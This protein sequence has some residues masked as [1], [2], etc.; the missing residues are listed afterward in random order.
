MKNEKNP[1]PLSHAV[2]L[3]APKILCVYIQNRPG[4]YCIYTLLHCGIIRSPGESWNKI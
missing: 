4:F 3:P 2:G 1:G